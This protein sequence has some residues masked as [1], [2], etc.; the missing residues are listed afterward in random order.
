MRAR[1]ATAFV[2]SLFLACAGPAAAQDASSGPLID[3]VEIVGEEV[4]D[5]PSTG[6]VTFYRT[7]NK[8]HLNTREQVIRRELLFAPGER[9][10][11]ERLEQTERNL[12]SLT[13]LRDARVEVVDPDADDGEGTGVTVRVRTWDAWSLTPRIDVDRV[14][15][16]TIWDVGLTESNL[17]GLGK[18]VTV[19]HRSDLDRTSD[20]VWYSDPQLAG[21][22][23]TLTA[24]AAD[25]SDGGEGFVTLSRPYYSLEDPWAFTV[26]AGAFSRRDR[27]FAGGQE[28]AQLGRRGQL[29]DV[30]YGRAV[31]RRPTSALRLHAAYR[32]RDDR[33]GS[34]RRDFGIVEAGIRS[35][36]HRFARLTHVNRFERTEDFNLGAQS[37]A[38]VGLS[39][40]AFGGGEHRV[41][42]LSTGH[43][44]GVGFGPGH[45][46]VADVG[47]AGRHERDRWVN[48]VAVA[49]ARYLR[50]HAARH[51][52]IGR[53][54]LAWGHELDPEVQL[55]LGTESGLR[56][57]PVRQFAGTRSLLL[58][59]EERWFIADDIWQLF[60]LGAAAFVDSGFVWPEGAGVRLADLRTAVGVGLLIGSNRLLLTGGGVRMDV[61]Y[62]LRPLP[63]ISPWVVSF[64]SDISF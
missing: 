31:R 3:A 56:G 41:L 14:N 46:L 17:L 21:S 33:I 47:L 54:G 61:G 29:G 36:E 15:D 37:W 48:T 10:N 39:A 52:L 18:S 40:P 45:F 38:T 55:L 62:A 5:E 64:G 50:K 25:L 23:F 12:R 24:S 53:A 30:E 42:T 2:T 49:R 43:A 44:R 19:S 26:R 32:L 57:Y 22:R 13:F 7:A 27:L 35:V 20:R 58:T 9:L 51:L 34:E 60:S 6:F 63:G 28:I 4:F 16:R 59:A 1:L 8:L 11:A